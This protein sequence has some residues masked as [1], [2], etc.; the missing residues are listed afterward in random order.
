MFHIL[1]WEL[2]KI[3]ILA[4]DEIPQTT[5]LLDNVEWKSAVAQFNER[6]IAIENEVGPLLRKKFN[7][8]TDNNPEK[9]LSH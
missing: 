6:F 8:P 7:A 5:A 9:V 1:K 4:L 2:R 3:Q